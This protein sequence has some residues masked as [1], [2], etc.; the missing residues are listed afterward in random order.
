MRLFEGII[1]LTCIAVVF[2]TVGKGWNSKKYANYLP[3]ISLLVL[4]LHAVVEG[5]RWQF[6]PL[7]MMITVYCAATLIKAIANGTKQRK[8]SILIN[9]LV[10][11]CMIV[12]IVI[13]AAAAYA[14]P[15]Y[16]L[17]KPAGPYKIGTMSFNVT[18]NS[19]KEL[20]GGAAEEARRVRMQM[21]YPADDVEGYKAVPWLEDGVVVAKGVARAMKLPE[22]LLTHT[23]LIKS[24]SYRSAPISDKESKYPI[25]V[26]S[27]GWTGF[28]N[29]HTDVAELLASNGYIVLSIDHTYGS[30]ATVFQNGEV[31]Y[32]DANALPKRNETPD[33]L[34]YAN[35][36]VNT[37]AGDIE[38]AVQ[39]LDGLNLG[40]VEPGFQ[41]K[42]DLDKIGLL[43]HSTGGGAAVTTALRNSGIAAVMGLDA[44]VEPIRKEELE[45]GLH[46]PALFL[47]SE[48]WETGFN[49]EHLFLLFERSD[50]SLRAYQINEANHMDFSM[51]YMYSPLSKYLNFTGKLNGWQGA[52]I[53]QDYIKNFFDSSLK[54]SSES[55]V[56]ALLH[57]Y[58]QLEDIYIR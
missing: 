53:Q 15:L 43:G 13:T 24:N 29:L 41:S 14:F 50:A 30:A 57:K 23:A 4:V 31:V 51:A 40:E 39:Q 5:I 26:I 12:L 19:R 20:Y 36:L 42:L 25:V 38:L 46:I 16:R 21:W 17:P 10:T 11:S 1:F 52:M 9:R 18:D 37:Y 55:A 35:R 6:Y 34:Q 33:F 49:N 22:F 56:D 3:I 27:H 44:W 8:A 45:K 48:Q 32:L 58:E 54:G 2:A 28:R 7:Y 47:R